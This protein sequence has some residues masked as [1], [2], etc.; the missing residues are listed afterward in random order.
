MTKPTPNR[1]IKTPGPVCPT[2]LLVLMGAD[3]LP[4]VQRD[5]ATMALSQR[6]Y[7]RLTT[8]GFCPAR[9]V[10]VPTRHPMGGERSARLLQRWIDGG[11]LTLVP[12]GLGELV[13][14]SLTRVGTD[15]DQELVMANINVPD[16]TPVER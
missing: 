14:E 16:W 9:V 2:W 4:L 15:A 5:G 7:L 6:V 13:T 1:H 10:A 11:R 12:G 8:E 3:P